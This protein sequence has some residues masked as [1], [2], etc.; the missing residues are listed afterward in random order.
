MSKKKIFAI[1]IFIVFGLFMF[2][3]ANP[4][5]ID[6][7]YGQVEVDKTKL[8]DAI[9]RGTALI[10]KHGTGS[11][12]LKELDEAVKDGKDVYDDESTQ[13]EVDDATK[14]IEDAIKNLEDDIMNRAKFIS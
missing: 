4:I 10:E 7:P 9:D 8:K 3:F 14:R 6:N 12:V 5:E 13:D 11:D 1:I 2:S